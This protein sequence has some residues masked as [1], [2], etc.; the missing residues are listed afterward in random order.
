M[1]TEDVPQLDELLETLAKTNG[2]ISTLETKVHALD[3]DVEAT[4]RAARMA[5]A[6]WTQI[7]TALGV[8]KQSAWERYRHLDP[9]VAS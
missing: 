1:K 9:E 8:K 6:T 7:G 4:V 2:Q 5:G 3:G